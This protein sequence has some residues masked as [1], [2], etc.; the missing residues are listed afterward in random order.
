MNKYALR[1]SPLAITI[2]SVLAG[3]SVQ[4]A[5]ITVTTSADG[6]VGS[7]AG[8][9]LREAIASANNGN[10][11]GG[12]PSGSPAADTIAFDPS[13]DGSTITLTDGVMEITNS[14]TIDGPVPEDPAGLTIDG[15]NL[16]RIFHVEG[17][18][19]V[20][21]INA[22]FNH[23]T[24]TRGRATGSY[25]FGGAVN[26]LYANLHLEHMLV[27]GNSVSTSAAG[28]YASA[29]AAGGG[30]AV[31][32]GSAN[33][34]ESVVSGNS[35]AAS[36]SGQYASSSALGGALVV[37][38]GAV[39]IVDS[40]ISGNH[41]E[42]EISGEYAFGAAAG[43]LIVASGGLT[44][45]DS[46]V[47]DNSVQ[48]QTS[49]PDADAVGYAGAAFISATDGTIVGSTM[50]GNSVDA[51][52]VV[53]GGGLAITG[54]DM[55]LR[56]STISGNTLTGDD[57]RGGGVLLVGR[58]GDA[59]NDP[60][61][62]SLAVVHGS[63]AF[64]STDGIYAT[65]NSYTELVLANSLIV[66]GD[67]G[68]T[69]CGGAGAKYI[70][71]LATDTSCTGAAT[72]SADINLTELANNGGLTR[73]HALLPGSVAIDGAGDCDADVSVTTDQRGQPRPGTGSSA[74]DI[75]AFELQADDDFDA[76]F[77]DRFE[78]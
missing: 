72:D 58:E 69:A 19:P 53:A 8:C 1:R 36:A 68:E 76:I 34:I 66:Q 9:S 26:A 12:C 29:A 33:L 10:S 31:R 42:S 2:G 63:V 37:L 49:D 78:Q 20:T 32:Y 22:T 16:S 57:I 6:A 71:S 50:S 74:C 17:P 45:V 7:V 38:N 75:G 47:S 73:T 18:S 5:T 15:D 4:A 14:V 27:M 52:D 40:T 28:M 39:E 62:A 55:T 24:L 3:G 30:L 13:L 77:S 43:A 59:Y 44:M 21:P 51:G 11:Q 25:E 67:A 35:T 56:N 64:N 61:P 46:T 65:S 70:N 54:S 41:S 60:E 23:L 48:S